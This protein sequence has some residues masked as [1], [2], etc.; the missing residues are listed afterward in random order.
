MIKNFPSIFKKTKDYNQ[1]YYNNIFISEIKTIDN[2]KKEI[3]IV[4]FKIDDYLRIKLNKN[5]V[6]LYN[7]LKMN[8]I[9]FLEDEIISLC[10]EINK[11]LF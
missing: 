10:D 1:I 5:D 6:I 3:N 7:E 4:Y 2:P 11:L 9:S 8:K